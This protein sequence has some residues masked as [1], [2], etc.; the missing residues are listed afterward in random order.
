MGAWFFVGLLPDGAAV[1]ASLSYAIEK[2]LTKHS[3][4]F[5]RGAVEGVAG[6]ESA[7]NSGTAGALFPC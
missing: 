2:R 5:G 4:E 1:L 6:P 7:N 3:D